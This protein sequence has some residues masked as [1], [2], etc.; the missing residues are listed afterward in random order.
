MA[1]F[2]HCYEAGWTEAI[3]EGKNPSKKIMQWDFTRL[4][5]GFDFNAW[6]PWNYQES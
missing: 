4:A 6:L 3:S 2:K 5:E 1:L